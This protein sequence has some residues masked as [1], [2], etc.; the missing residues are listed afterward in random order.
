MHCTVEQLTDPD[1][2]ARVVVQ[3]ELDLAAAPMLRDALDGLRRE[4][5]STVLD[6]RELTFMDS[7][8]L[9][10]LLEAG[11]HRAAGWGVSLLLPAG[12][13]VLGL[14][15]LDPPREPGR[16]T[17]AQDELVVL[18][19]D[20]ILERTAT[21]AEPFGDAGLARAL[22]MLEEPSPTAAVATVIEAVRDLDDAGPLR[23]DASIL[24][25]APDGGQR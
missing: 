22:N 7:S 1:G 4:A 18:V 21:G 23:D 20:G 24:V 25:L 16:A 14:P 6:L 13:P 17:I 3:G 11:Q 8:G 2:T 10:V 19:T 12:G 5:R 9:R 15:R